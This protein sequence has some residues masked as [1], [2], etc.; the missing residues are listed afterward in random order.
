MFYHILLKRVGNIFI[1]YLISA[2]VYTY[3]NSVIIYLRLL[4]HCDDIES[5]MNIISNMLSLCIRWCTN[6]IH[7]ADIV[8]QIT[9]LVSDTSIICHIIKFM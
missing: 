8:A 5:L 4:F 2:Y 6:N 1:A 3:A 7:R 9:L